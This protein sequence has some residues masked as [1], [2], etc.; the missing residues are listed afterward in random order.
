MADGERHSPPNPPLPPG[1]P[2]EAHMPLPPPMGYYQPV[3]G[4]AHWQHQH[5]HQQAYDGSMPP[6]SELL[7]REAQAWTALLNLHQ[8]VL[9]TARQLASAAGETDP[10]LETTREA[11]ETR[12]AG[13]YAALTQ[14][15]TNCDQLSAEALRLRALRKARSHT[16]TQSLEVLMHS[17]AAET[18]AI[19]STLASNSSMNVSAVTVELRQA[20]AATRQQIAQV[21][22]L[23]QLVQDQPQLRGTL[24]IGLRG[25]GGG[26]G[27]GVASEEQSF[28]PEEVFAAVYR[29][30]SELTDDA[31][32]AAMHELCG[33]EDGTSAPAETSVAARPRTY[34]RRSTDGK[35]GSA[36]R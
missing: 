25:E 28:S 6:V 34:V 1:P 15:A 31:L 4:H 10:A 24:R 32:V 27:E 16:D 14:L 33:I 3:S 35:G 20:T 36:S 2:P 5:Q 7:M 8:G 9:G 17:H 12:E 19:G 13:Y 18:L 23:L 30:A 21:R 22:T 11:I 26:E 29:H